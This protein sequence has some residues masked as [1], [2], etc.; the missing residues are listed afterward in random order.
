[1]N[2]IDDPVVPIAST[3]IPADALDPAQGAEEMPTASDAPTEDLGAI[4]TNSADITYC[5]Q[6]FL[7]RDPNRA[8]AYADLIGTKIAGVVSKLLLEQEFLDRILPAV[9]LRQELPHSRIG[10]TPPQPIIDWAQRRLPIEP[11]TRIAL[12]VAFGWHRLLETLLA[13]RKLAGL[14][15]RLLAAGID[16]TLR[17]RLET[18]GVYRA[19]R[20]V[21]GAVEEI[22]TRQVCG[23]AADLFDRSNPVTVELHVGSVCIGTVTCGEA[24]PD[25]ADQV[26]AGAASGFTFVLAEGHRALC[27]AGETLRVID[28]LSRQ[29]IGKG[30]ITP[31]EEDLRADVTSGE[32]DRLRPSRVIPPMIPVRPNDE[33]DDVVQCYRLFLGRVPTQRETAAG[34][35]PGSVAALLR[36]LLATDEFIGEVLTPVLLRKELPHAR[37]AAPI[38]WLTLDRAQR[39]LPIGA[40]TRR[41]IGT[42]R[43]WALLPRDR[44][45]RCR[46]RL[47][48]PA[49][50]GRRDRSDLARASRKRGDLPG[51][52]FGGQ[53]PRCGQPFQRPRLGSR[54]L[55]QIAPG[56][57]R[58]LR[59]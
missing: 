8:R 15:P 2:Q 35:E 22:S 10:E 39:R 9:L 7:G 56:H 31:A 11:A 59:R 55:R 1:M 18:E 43:S 48:G 17:D 34:T 51:R 26:G 27:A 40:A 44:I 23:W 14:A 52:I 49:A 42:A 5:C 29:Q 28:A 58:V 16:A 3:A 30:P 53:E 54:S 21:I 32:A 20:S 46:S 50:A 19:L 47:A 36:D 45:G 37:I 38:S 6:L 12:G 33:M 4:A 13:D 57:D 25:I 24:R 41:A